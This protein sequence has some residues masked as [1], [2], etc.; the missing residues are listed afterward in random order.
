[1]SNEIDSTLTEG[2]LKG[3]AGSEITDIQR[4]GIK[5][6][7]SHIQLDLRRIYDD[8]WFVGSHI[9][10]GQ[11]LIEVEGARFTR[12]YAG[13]TPEPEKLK[14]LGLTPKEVSRYLKT[15]IAKLGMQTRLFTECNPDA[16]G[17]WQYSYKI[18]GNYDEVPLTT[19]VE[20][21]AYQG[22]IVHVHTFMLCA[23][24]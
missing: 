15:M 12:L 14:E 11:E 17:D 6:K 13:G 7:A 2:L 9:G 8:Q 21:I 4:S 10:G 19:A 24:K 23:I 18:N 5:G 22:K 1:M 16:D 20:S 3:Y